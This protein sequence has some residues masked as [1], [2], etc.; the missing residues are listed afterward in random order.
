[1]HAWYSRRSRTEETIQC[2]YASKGTAS[3][4]VFDH[5][6][7]L[8]HNQYNQVLLMIM[9]KANGFFYVLIKA[10]LMTLGRRPHLQYW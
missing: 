2:N 7:Q 8:L 6:G 9:K 4:A 1:M 5:F 10:E 3:D